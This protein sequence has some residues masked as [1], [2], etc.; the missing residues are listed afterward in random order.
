MKDRMTFEHEG[1]VLPVFAGGAPIGTNELTMLADAE[2]K[3]TGIADRLEAS[4]SE[5]RGMTELTQAAREERTIE[6]RRKAVEEMAEIRESARKATESLTKTIEG[7]EAK[8]TPTGEALV[9]RQLQEAQATTKVGQLLD[10]NRSP[11]Q[12]AEAAA[13]MRSPAIV[14]ALIDELQ[15]RSFESDQ[16]VDRAAIRQLEDALIPMVSAEEAEVITTKRTADRAVRRF[17]AR[18]RLAESKMGGDGGM[19]AAVELK[20]LEAEGAST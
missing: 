13:E 4:L 15:W 14:R 11:L 1:R 6:A 7:A 9:A 2:T 8:L 20:Q 12:I 10:A 17:D 5:I 19:A 18:V 3:A 16:P